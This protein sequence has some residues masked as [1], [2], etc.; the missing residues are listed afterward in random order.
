MARSRFNIY[1]DAHKGLRLLL[2]E[3]TARVDRTDFHT[4][5]EVL[6]LRDELS[7]ALKLL[8]AHTHYETAFL[9]PL[10][11]LYCAE[12]LEGLQAEHAEEEGRL[13]ELCQLLNAVEPH[14]SDASQRGH[15][16]STHLGM[17]VGQLL[18]HMSREEQEVL[19]ALWQKI[20]D[21]TLQTVNDSLLASIPY[22]DRAIWL[23]TLLR[24]LNRPERLTLLSRMRATMPR[25]AFDATI[26][27]VRAEL[28]DVHDSLTSD[29]Q[30]LASTAA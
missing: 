17:V 30:L 18:Q 3:L 5:E 6:R 20:S 25:Q 23:K 14:R 1:R 8:R 10:I 21:K 15:A 28:R 26:E 9:G 27:S 24:A 13:E 22:L 7:V 11:K 2:T 4:L 29:L 12:L 19:P 16:F